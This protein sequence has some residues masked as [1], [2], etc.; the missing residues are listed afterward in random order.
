MTA[1]WSRLGGARSDPRN[2]SVAGGWKVVQGHRGRGAGDG[3]QDQS[4]RRGGSPKGTRRLTPEEVSAVV[5]DVIRRTIAT[6]EIER[7]FAALE[8]RDKKQKTMSPRETKI[9]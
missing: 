7:R 8:Q 4:R 5:L 1:S 3:P 9:T 6:I 2:S